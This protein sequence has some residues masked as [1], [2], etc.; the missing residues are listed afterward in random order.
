VTTDNTTKAILKGILGGLGISLAIATSFY[1]Y[2]QYNHKEV[3]PQDLPVAPIKTTTE[4]SA[5]PKD[6]PSDNDLEVTQTYRATVN[7]AVVTAPI[8]TVT[9]NGTKGVIKQEVDVQPIVDLARKTGY[10]EAKK[11]YRKTSIEFGLG[12]GV[13]DG[14]SYIPISVEKVYSHG[15]L[16]DKAVELEVHVDI[17]ESTSNVNLKVTGG[18][19]KHKWRF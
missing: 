15:K 7:G 14:D 6:S 10:E 1:F 17:P 9:P 12:Y 16:V 13:H 11:E 2:N 8:K 4:L 5:V 3:T 18:E 19:V